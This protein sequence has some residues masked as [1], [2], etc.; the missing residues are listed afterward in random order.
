MF[1]LQNLKFTIG[2]HWILFFI[3]VVAGLIALCCFIF[4]K[5][6]EME[7]KVDDK[8]FILVRQ[9]LDLE[10]LEE[11]YQLKNKEI[12]ELHRMN[13]SHLT[14]I[15][16]RIDIERNLEEKILALERELCEERESYLETSNPHKS[17]QGC[18][19]IRIKIKEEAEN[20]TK[21]DDIEF[22][23]L[24]QRLVDLEKENAE[25]QAGIERLLAEKADLHLSYEER[26]D[27]ECSQILGAVEKMAAEKDEHFLHK[28]KMEVL[29]TEKKEMQSKY[30]KLQEVLGSLK[31]DLEEETRKYE[32]LTTENELLKE[33]NE[34]L[35]E[36]ME[37]LVEKSHLSYEERLDKKCS[38]ILGAVE[39]MAAEKD[40]HFLHKTKMEVLETEKKE[41]QSKYEKLHQ[42]LGSLKDDLQEET[43]KYEVQKTENELLKEWN[44][45]LK[46]Q[47]ER[48]VEKSRG[49]NEAVSTVTRAL[50]EE[51]NK[52]GILEAEMQTLKDN[53]SKLESENRKLEKQVLKGKSERILESPK[54]TD[55]R[56]KEKTVEELPD[57]GN[58]LFQPSTN[59]LDSKADQSVGLQNLDSAD[60]NEGTERAIEKDII[61]KREDNKCEH[62]LSDKGGEKVEMASAIDRQNA[63]AD[64]LRKRLIDIRNI[65]EAKE[66]KLETMENHNRLLAHH[67][68][69]KSL[70]I[71]NSNEKFYI[72]KTELENLKREA[73]HL[74]RMKRTKDL[75]LRRMQ[76]QLEEHLTRICNELVERFTPSE[77]L[78]DLGEPDDILFSRR[79]EESQERQFLNRVQR[80]NQ[81]EVKE[82]SEVSNST[83]QELKGTNKSPRVIQ[84]PQVPT[85]CIYREQKMEET[86]VSGLTGEISFL[87]KQLSIEYENCEFLEK[88]L[89][90]CQQEN[91]KM[92]GDSSQQLKDIDSYNRNQEICVNGIIHLKELIERY[93]VEIYNI[94][95]KIDRLQIQAEEFMQ[96]IEKEAT[97]KLRSYIE[98]LKSRF[99]EAITAVNKITEDKESEESKTISIKSKNGKAEEL[100]KEMPSPI[101]ESVEK[102]LQEKYP[103]NFPMEKNRIPPPPL[104]SQLPPDMPSIYKPV[105]WPAHEIDIDEIQRL[106]L[107]RRERLGIEDEIAEGLSSEK[108]SGNAYQGEGLGDILE[109]PSSQKSRN[110]LMEEIL[111]PPPPVGS[112]HPN[113]LLPVHRPLVWHVDDVI[114]EIQSLALERRARLGIEDEIAEGLSSEKSSGNAYQGEGLGDILEEPSSQKSR[115]SLMEE[116]LI[117][118]PPV[119][120]PH[121]ND[122][123]PVHRPLVWHVDDVINEIQSLALE[124]R[125]RL[126]IE[127]EIAEGLS[128]EKS[129]GNGYQGEGLGDILEEPS[130]QKS[131]NSLMEEILIP[132]PPVGSPHPND[133]FPVHRPLVW[134]V[135]DVI[136]EIQSLA[137][138]RRA[139]LGIE[140]EI[141]EGLSSE[142]SSGDAYQGK[143]LSDILKEPS[144]EK[145]SRNSPMGFLEKKLIPLPLVGS[146]LPPNLPSI[147]RPVVWPAHKVDINEIQR[148]AQERRERL[149]IED[150]IAEGSSTRKTSRKTYQEGDLRDK[151]YKSVEG[152]TDRSD[153]HGELEAQLDYGQEEFN[154]ELKRKF[155]TESQRGI[156]TKV[157]L[158]DEVYR[159]GKVDKECKPEMKETNKDK[160]VS[161]SH[162]GSTKIITELE[163]EF[164][165]LKEEAIAIRKANAAMEKEIEDIRE[166][167]VRLSR[168]YHKRMRYAEEF[169]ERAFESSNLMFLSWDRLVHALRSDVRNKDLEMHFVRRQLEEHLMGK[170]NELVRRLE[171]R[172]AFMANKFQDGMH[173]MEKELELR[174]NQDQNEKD[175]TEF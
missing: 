16:R 54:E 111:I 170:M 123:L 53:V 37:R 18:R 143:G 29:E 125:A 8:D 72:C 138:E 161:Y 151:D 61:W 120:S 133:L 130:S 70:E 47:M 50:A 106:P 76:R 171:S 119:G 159:R 17:E 154:T 156:E 43:L 126:G 5:Y 20:R 114:N 122:L 28:T 9:K 4:K 2:I 105:V 83:D 64:H 65:N 103:K 7:N 40:E 141:A 45:E 67:L 101:G 21:L 121:P 34:E 144:P 172:T 6:L 68:Y 147:Y 39:K 13:Q 148:L 108:S 62:E 27:K 88:Q 31:D 52:N 38:Q 81:D 102:P 164:H 167:C 160:L 134:H 97:F 135:D 55:S 115:N 162:E 94:D 63:E 25:A 169:H 33:W 30:E 32:V 109:E 3:L 51:K 158:G 59:R 48:L 19:Q 73:Q 42:V 14:E 165:Q 10:D 58:R 22:D 117:P 132:P 86:N 163:D 41:I 136:N 44:E 107:E 99:Q 12:E 56:L 142:K 153:S 118:P 166:E 77:V 46:E 15:E 139:R 131:R 24:R 35:K 128:S 60:S 113:D 66:K 145:H 104:G 149:G 78:M 84:F 91:V 127:D 98:F 150:E 11:E 155:D 112:P 26:L 152:S 23:E 175:I 146:P 71:R 95:K 74:K 92:I 116:I 93:V 157:H 140:D 79:I 110:S 36:Q 80:E 49:G 1:S 85:D 82:M 124:R 89:D 129:S 96:R 87:K 174:G 75:Q 69:E 90:L 137:L 57:A 100:G 168:I 173:L